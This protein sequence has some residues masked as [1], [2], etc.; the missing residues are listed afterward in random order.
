M[1]YLLRDILELLLL[2]SALTTS[3]DAA[4]CGLAD[5]DHVRTH[6]LKGPA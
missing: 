2:H 4:C 5:A 3:D 6:G 1:D